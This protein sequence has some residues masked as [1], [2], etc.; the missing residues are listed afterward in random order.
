MVDSLPIWQSETNR[1]GLCPYV[2]PLDLPLVQAK[3]DWDTAKKVLG[4]NI[5]DKLKNYDKV[6]LTI[7]R[8]MTQ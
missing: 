1:P 3:T 2:L 7:Y 4:D 6:G 5:L 8:K